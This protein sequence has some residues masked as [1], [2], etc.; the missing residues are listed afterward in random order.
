TD[1]LAFS[2]VLIG[3]SAG[4]W[5]IQ[6]SVRLFTR[7]CGRVI[8]PSGAIKEKMRAIGSP[9]GRIEKL[10]R[11]VDLTR[12][13]P[14]KRSSGGWERFAASG[15][16]RWMGY[17]GRVTREMGVELLAEACPTLVSRFP[18]VRLAVVGEGPNRGDVRK[19][20]REF[21]Q[22]LFPGVLRDEDLAGI[23]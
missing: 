11:G 12:F 1:V 22:A 21:G 13:R 18:G 17:F 5:I 4:R 2:D 19:R 10:P 7:L 3:N 14:D 6:A 20:L 23:L 15:D 9:E 8:V 16:G